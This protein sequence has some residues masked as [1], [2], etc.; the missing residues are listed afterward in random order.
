DPP[1]VA[2][3]PRRQPAPHVA[4]AGNRRDEVE[5]LEDVLARKAL[6]DAEREGGA[7]DAAA[8]DRQAGPQPSVLGALVNLVDGLAQ[9][10]LRGRP[11]LVGEEGIE[12]PPVEVD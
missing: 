11:Y 9:P 5:P 2:P 7:A 4:A 10:R 8:G 12:H 1:A 6:Q 3:G